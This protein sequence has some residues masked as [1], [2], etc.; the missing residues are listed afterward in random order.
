MTKNLTFDNEMK[1]LSLGVYKDNKNS[2]PKDWVRFSE[3]DNESTG[4][5]AETFYK[6]GAVVIS[7]RGT[8]DYKDL[9]ENDFLQMGR[10]KLPNQYVDAINY[11]NEIQKTFPSSKI[12]FTGHSLGGSLAQLMGNLTGNETVTFNAY[13][14]GNL[15]NGNINYENSKNIR[16]Y[17]NINDLV[18]MMNFDNQLGHTQVINSSFD[19]DFYLTKGYN[20]SYPQGGHDLVHHKIEHMGNLE[21]S[22]S[23]VSPEEIESM[24]LFGGVNLDIDLRNLDTERIITNEEIKQMSNEEFS[25]NENFINQQLMAGNIMTEMQA[26]EQL[27]AGNLIWVNSYTRADGTEV[28]G[29]YRR[30]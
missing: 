8:D 30:K 2:I 24:I 10:N 11:Y 15:L 19:D 6:K 1:A 18:F 13:G 16:N 14:V 20:G 3:R 5:H 25:Q 23:Y 29:Y 21:N 26:K 7:F 12:V 28:K 17:G 4:F 9:F 22:A 27:E